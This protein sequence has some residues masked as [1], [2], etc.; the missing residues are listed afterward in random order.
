MNYDSI[1]KMVDH[2]THEGV[3]ISDLIL[4][5]QSIEME[6][7]E[8]AIFDKMANSFSVMEKAADEGMRANEKSASGLT[9]CDAYKIKQ[10]LDNNV[11]VGGKIVTAMIARAIGVAERN[12]CMGK[13]VA[14]PTAGSCGILPAAL[15]TIQEE[16]EIP[17]E[18]IIMSLLTASALGMVISENASVAGAKGG[19]QAEC[20]SAAAMAA[21][22][23]VEAMG[24]TPEMVGH[25]CAIAIKSILGLVCD[26]VGGLVEVPCV[27][28]NASG[29]MNALTAAELALAGVESYI[30]ADEVILTMKAVGD[31]MPPSLKETSKGGLAATNTAKHFSLDK[32]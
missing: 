31:T 14:A 4:K 11:S 7:D 24:G 16:H 26:P 23:I 29:A 5:D 21:G 30:P 27:K 9:G 22:A 20:G 2:A 18:K 13:I 17:R 8:Q 15:I 3:N 28:R 1:Q 19:C 12:A 6:M 10:R 32:K 25:A